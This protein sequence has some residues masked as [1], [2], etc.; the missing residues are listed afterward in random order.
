MKRDSIEVL[1]WCGLGAFIAIWMLTISAVSAKGAESG[2]HAASTVIV[3]QKVRSCFQG[4]ACSET[5]E[6]GTGT[7][8]GTVD[9]DPNHYVVVTARHCIDKGPVSVRTADGWF[10]IESKRLHPSLDCGFVTFYSKRS[11]P[12][13]A[14]DESDP[15]VGESASWLGYPR[16]NWLR[17]SSGSIESINGNIQITGRSLHGESGGGVY[18]R[19]CLCGVVWGTDDRSCFAT[20]FGPFCRWVRRERYAIRFGGEVPPP[21]SVAEKPVPLPLPAKP[22]NATDL[23]P[24][25]SVL[26]TI[27]ARLTLL[28]SRPAAAGPPGERGPPGLRGEPGPAGPAGPAGSSASSAAELAELRRR[29]G[30]LESTEIPVHILNPDG[31]VKLSKSVPLGQP[32][33]FRLLPVASE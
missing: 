11:Y 21:P 30:K 10:P 20:P 5:A 4:Q 25:L 23:T 18:V 17:N 27:S 32:I 22:V 13:A 12:I 2:S 7:I 16:D 15:A 28:E 1:L 14:V 19:G 3:R 8:I 24:V 6:S 29:L 33:E 26:E 31:S 9:G